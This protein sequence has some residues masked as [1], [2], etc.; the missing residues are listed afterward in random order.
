MLAPEIAAL[1]PPLRLSDRE[2]DPLVVARFVTADG[3]WYV[4]EGHAIND[5]FR[6][7]G[8]RLTGRAGG[9]CYWTY[10]QIRRELGPQGHPVEIE[11]MPGNFR[12]SGII[13]LERG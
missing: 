4:L 12:L 11:L 3:V 8:V 1:I 10:S 7:F 2:D 6:F 9:F 13:G 5:D